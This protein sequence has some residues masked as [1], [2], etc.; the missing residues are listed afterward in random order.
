MNTPPEFSLSAVNQKRQSASSEPAAVV[1][2]YTAVAH[3]VPTQ[4]EAALPLRE[5]STGETPR[6]M[7]PF[8]PLRVAE[9]LWRS[10]PRCLVVACIC[11]LALFVLARLRI[12]SHYTATAQLV[13]QAVPDSF[14]ATEVGESYKPTEIP[15]PILTSNIMRSRSLMDRVAGLTN[16][17]TDAQ[18]ILQGITVNTDRKTEVISAS[19][20]S[21]VSPARAVEII[22]RYADEVVK[23]T[24]ELQAHDAQEM[25]SFLKKQL[26]RCDADLLK[27][28][29]EILS[30]AEQAQLLDGDKEMTAYLSELGNLDL[31]Y[32][33]L[34]L[35]YETLDLKLQS[36]ERELAKASP[37]AS[38]LQVARGELTQL[39]NRYTEKNPIVLEQMDRIKALE[40]A[41]KSESESS[42]DEPPKGGESPVAVSL[43]LQRVDLLSQKN[44]YAEQLTKL[45]QIREKLADKLKQLPRKNL[46]YTQM[47]ARQQ[48]LDSTR[49]L[50]ASRQRE[51][52]LHSENSPGYYR[53]IQDAHVEDVVTDT[54][55][56]KKL[57]AGAAGAAIGF[58]AM[59]A[60][61]IFRELADSR[62]KTPADLRR[63]THLP[64]LASFPA[65]MSSDASAQETW[66]FRTWTRLQ[67]RLRTPGRALV[68]GLLTEREPENCAQLARMLGDAAAWRGAPVL[69]ITKDPP[70]ERPT[71]TLMEAL[72]PCLSEADRWLDKG[73][74][75]V[76]LKVDEHWEWTSEQRGK[77]A[78]AL[79]LWSRRTHAVIFVELPPA[80]RP[81]TLLM[82]ERLPQILWVGAGG[83][84][85]DSSLAETLETYRHAGCHFLGAMLNRAPRL[86][87]AFLNQF[88]GVLSVWLLAL[89]PGTLVFGEDKPIELTSLEDVGSRASATIKAE[90]VPAASA[91]SEAPPEQAYTLGA[92]DVINLEV[93]RQVGS[94]RKGIEIR[95]DGRI[96]YL[97]AQDVLAA[98]LTI[99]QLRVKLREELSKYYHHP[100][101]MVTPVR[102]ESRKVYV[103]GKVVKKG[104]VN[105]D[106]PLTLLE[107]ITE[108]GGLETGMFQQNTVELADLGRSFLSRRGQRQKVNFEAL[109]MRGDM[110]QNVRLEPDDYIYLP[111]ANNNEIYVLGSVQKQG[112]QGL[113]AQTSVTS[114]ITLAGGFT[115][116]AY[117]SKVL[118]I[119]GSLDHPETVVV[120]VAAI[121][122]GKIKDIKLQP[123]DIVFVAD[124]PWARAEELLDMALSSFI[125]GAVTGYTNG[126]IGPFITRPII[127]A[128][129]G[130]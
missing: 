125:Q 75:V 105:F 1:E 48:A 98:G 97:Q 112:T 127:N 9:A 13:K 93:F 35:D 50:L 25:N 103:L 21:D 94:I 65:E 37:T 72:G 54:R 62:V 92:G 104:M 63:V 18:I 33:T 46:E 57:L 28:N 114:A 84:P 96:S 52:E 110:S 116:K 61:Y 91:A 101:V 106:R 17:P 67:M 111:S 109:F 4:S 43:Y 38:S 74:G 115:P 56:S 82:A 71:L 55:M 59:A 30:Y 83:E 99:D 58:F 8:D 124:K 24:Q 108:A 14:R 88:A 77:L 89:L 117:R 32:E 36:V 128:V 95:P 87:P 12:E 102:F 70:G 40:D 5:D 86:Q 130:E 6:F 45:A 11:G 19:Y 79:E 76:F 26:A 16:P 23:L 78:D 41:L 7:L 100:V 2:E 69:I 129:G 47:R 119:H 49:Q 29:E 85:S 118:V 51:A 34:R 27:L 44:I 126:A 121:L 10:A 90:P 120:D 122:K 113:L 81:E 39:L 3:P 80:S 31:K 107:A 20:T 15:V 64:V 66:A 123:N 22:T 53:V 68:C 42:H 73:S 60:W